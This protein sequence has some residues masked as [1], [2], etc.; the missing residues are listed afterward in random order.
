[1]LRS[2]FVDFSSYNQFRAIYERQVAKTSLSRRI[3]DEKDIER[4]S[5]NSNRALMI[6][7]DQTNTPTPE[8]LVDT[9]DQGTVDVLVK[10]WIQQSWFLIE[11]STVL[12]YKKLKSLQMAWN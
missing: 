10:N 6:F 11:S 2:D 4:L 5:V 8:P 3:V 1:M 12:K 9:G 7:Q